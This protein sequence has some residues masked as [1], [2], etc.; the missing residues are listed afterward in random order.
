MCL[1]LLQIVDHEIQVLT[2]YKAQALHL[3]CHCPRLSIR[4]ISSSIHPNKDSSTLS[5]ITASN[6]MVDL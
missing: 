6:P 3:L 5:G 2:F 4:S 1:T